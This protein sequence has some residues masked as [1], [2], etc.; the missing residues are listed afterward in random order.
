MTKV[1]LVED[2][3]NLR[4]IYEARLAAEGYE[5]A[6]AKDGE[7]ALAVAK[8]QKPDLI[9]SDVMMPRISGFEM[10]DIL[11]NTDG[12]KHTKVIMLTAL[13][14]AEDKSRAD[15]LGA[16]RYLVKSQVTLEDI[17]RAAEELLNPDAETAADKAQEPA[18]AP[19]QPPAPEP[20]PAVVTTP[21]PVATTDET[22]EPAVAQDDNTQ[23]PAV[24]VSPE[25]PAVPEPATEVAEEPV[26]ALA[27]EPTPEPAEPESEQVIQMPQPPVDPEVAALTETIQSTLEENNDVAQQIKEF[28]ET[29]VEP[30]ASS[31]QAETTTETLE[32]AAEAEINA[33]V[34]TLAT[35]DATAPIIE[36]EPTPAPASEPSVNQI[37][38]KTV[39]QPPTPDPTQPDISAL[40]AQEEYQEQTATAQPAV[41]SEP[42]PTPA[43]E[44]TESES[45]EEGAATPPPGGVFM[46]NNNGSADDSAL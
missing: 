21:P 36:S 11:R 6:T 30:T 31:S 12:M 17:V 38:G 34:D 41:S 25:T 35:T 13:G 22:P 24:A 4:E 42:V 9:I 27:P 28:E 44:V 18:V 40:L 29:P 10:L 23:Q 8:Q 46:P 1:L 14:Q 5:I 20:E 37:S 32:P 3:N 7:D 2:D 15:T 33:A 16:D 45:S 39:I 19:P 26:V 43:P